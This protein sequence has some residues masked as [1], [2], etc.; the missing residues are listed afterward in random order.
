MSENSTGDASATGEPRA[1]KRG[2]YAKGVQ[3]RRQIIDE[4]LT[5]YDGRGPYAKGVQRRRQ[6]IDEVLTVYDG[7]GAD[8]TSLR[9][10]ARAI[11]VSHSVL[12]HYFGSREELFLEVLQEQDDRNRAALDEN[13]PLH[14]NL[15]RVADL[16]TA[17]PG[18]MALL[19]NMVARALETGN[20]HSRAHFSARYAEAREVFAGLI[21]ASQRAGT[22]RTDL[23]A[24]EMSSLIL[25]AA[26]GLTT[27]WLLDGAVDFK[28]G[29][30]LLARLLE[31]PAG[32]SGTT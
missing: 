20:D 26:D 25:A 10:I 3:R 8:G 12:V 28:T 1:R 31:P 2:P 5:V 23:S 15:A 6:I 14:E 21:R 32:A 29:V 18:L 13:D 11:G 19:S 30:L 24:E 22:I 9:A 16:S 7:L 17:I 4:V 27:Q